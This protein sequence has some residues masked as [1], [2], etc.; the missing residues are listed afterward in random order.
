MCNPFSFSICPIEGFKFL[1]VTI[2]LF[3]VMYW[4]KNF[5]ETGKTCLQ[6][7]RLHDLL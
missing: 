6:K 7:K 2:R 1:V 4:L 3:L 5:L